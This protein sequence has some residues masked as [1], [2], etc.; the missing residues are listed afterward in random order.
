MGKKQQKK[1]TR[2]K[3]IVN[4]SK[5]SEAPCFILIKNEEA[6]SSMGFCSKYDPFPCLCN[7]DSD[8]ED[9]FDEYCQLL[10]AFEDEFDDNFIDAFEENDI[11]IE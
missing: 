8:E 2:R 5:Y 11:F 9:E 6:L 3:K 1:A 4:G 7:N 10:M